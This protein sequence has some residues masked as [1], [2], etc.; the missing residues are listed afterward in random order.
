MAEHHIDIT[1]FTHLTE[2][3]LLF[4]LQRRNHPDI[5][6]WMA[7]PEPISAESHLK[8]CAALKDKPDTLYLYVTYDGQ[9]ACVINLP[10]LS[11]CTPLMPLGMS[12]RIRAATPLTRLCVPPPSS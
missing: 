11:P 8:Y 1:N 4:I 7:H 3:Q 6:R 5:R 10:A 12:S 9:P 2:E